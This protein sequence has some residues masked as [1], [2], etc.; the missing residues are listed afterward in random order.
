MKYDLYHDESRVSGYWH[1]ILLIPDVNRKTLLKYLQKARDA[2]NYDLPLMLKHMRRK[3]NKYKCARLWLDIA[4]AS[5]MQVPKGS[6]RVYLGEKKYSRLKHCLSTSYEILLNIEEPLYVKFILLR[7][8]DDHAKMRDELFRDYG[9]KV[10]A[11]FRMG[12]KGGMH[13]LFSEE[14]TACTK[15]MHFDGY[16]HHSGR[17]INKQRIVS[18]LRMEFRSYCSISGNCKIDDRNLF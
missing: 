16:E 9:E 4:V 11:T 14:H 10:E 3:S 12:I 8:R 13:L 2:T 17:H 5:M 1:G 15:S 7:E 6:Y 18:R